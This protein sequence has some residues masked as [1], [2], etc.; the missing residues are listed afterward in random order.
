MEIFLKKYPISPFSALKHGLNI[1]IAKL[2]Q[3][4]ENENIYYALLLAYLKKKEKKKHAC[5]I[6][7]CQPQIEICAKFL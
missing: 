1:K 6:G 5:G 7:W 3:Q 2:V 4:T